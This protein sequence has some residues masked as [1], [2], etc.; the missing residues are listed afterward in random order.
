[1][2]SLAKAPFIASRPKKRIPK[3]TKISP[4]LFAVGDLKN[5]RTKPM[6]AVAIKNIENEKDDKETSKPVTVVP[7]NAP[8]MIEKP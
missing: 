3:P 7:K 8:S 6:K 4:T 2:F 5:P 1:M